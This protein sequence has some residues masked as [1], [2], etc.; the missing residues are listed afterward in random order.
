MKAVLDFVVDLLPDLG[1]MS[2]WIVAATFASRLSMKN[3]L[4]LS[5]GLN[6]VHV[7][8]ALLFR[9]AFLPHGS[10]AFPRWT[11]GLFMVEFAIAS[12]SLSLLGSRL[13]QTSVDSGGVIGLR[14][15]KAWAV[16]LP[17][18]PWKE[19][20]LVLVS[21]CASCAVIFKLASVQ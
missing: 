11:W 10:A 13:T 15:S 17:K 1:Y 5:V 19:P 2:L 8:C 7:I 14:E 21:F 20:T 9:R 16:E 4:S 12:V 18:T 3:Y 6:W